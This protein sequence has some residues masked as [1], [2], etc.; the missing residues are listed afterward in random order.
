MLFNFDQK[1]GPS[2]DPLIR[3]T[4]PQSFSNDVIEASKTRLVL[5]DF[6]APWCGPCAQLTPV[7]EQ[8]VR[9]AGDQISLVKVNMDDY[10]ELGQAL[11][12]QSMPTVFLFMN[13]QP[14]DMFVGLVS[15]GQLTALLIQHG[16]D[17]PPRDDGMDLG[18][19]ALSAQDYG[20]ALSFYG[21][22]LQ[23]DGAHQGA[24]LGIARSYIALGDLEK[25]AL[26]GAKLTPETLAG[27]E[28]R[29][30]KI[31]LSFL[32]TCT[33][34]P[35]FDDLQART[36]DNPLDFQSFYDISTYHFLRGNV[37]DSIDCLFHILVRDLQ[38]NDS[39]ARHKLLQILDV[40]G[41]S[42][43]RSGDARKR[44]SSLLFC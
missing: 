20:S 16:C 5:V 43:P 36:T 26:Y 14:V 28:G 10:P 12:V 19:A 18:N 27:P 25:S 38:W 40:I 13:G 34:L 29:A 15:A 22:V 6:W 37:G 21:A 35:P 2:S 17:L 31:H 23:K 8:A 3:D 4:N 30:F 41:F 7:L 44:L 39:A 1:Q 11:R 9:D 24:L 33:D 42:D 32:E